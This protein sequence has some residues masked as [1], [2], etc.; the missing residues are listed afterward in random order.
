[1]VIGYIKAVM[2]RHT[3][4]VDD[5]PVTEPMDT[6]SELPEKEKMFSAK[7]IPK[8]EALFREA[9]ADGSGGLDMEEFCV[10][11]EQLYG[12]VN[13]EEIIAL[14]MQIDSDCNTT[15]DI[16]ELMDFLLNKNKALESMDYKNQ[17]FPKPIKITV[18]EHCKNIVRLLFCPSMFD[19]QPDHDP[20]VSIG[21]IRTYQAGQ[22]ISISSDGILNFWTN[23]IDNP[24]TIALYNLK[25][26]LPFSHVKKMSVNDMVYI[27][28]LKEL[29]ISTS[30]RELLFYNCAAF[31]E[32][33][34]I[35]YSLIVEDNI[36]NTMNYWYKDSRAVFSF[37]DIKGLL[38]VFVSY[39]IKKN[40]L[41]CKE[42]YE[43]I[44]L[45]DYPTVYV[46]SLLKNPSKDFLCFKVPVFNDM[47]SEIKYFPS[48]HSFAVCGSSSKTMVLVGLPKLPRTKVSKKAFESRVDKEFFTCVEYCP[49]AERLVTGGT[50]G[51]LRVW[52]PHKTMSCEQE[53]TGHVKP[54]THIEYNHV[55][56]VFVSLSKDKNVRVWSEDG[57]LCRQSF[58]AHEMKRAPISSVYYN[59]HNNEL[60]LANSDI[61]K[62]FGRGTD[63]FKDTLTSHDKPLCGAL[64]HSIFKQVV[65]V[66]QT[67]W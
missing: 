34:R 48:L 23:N 12:S 52:F 54:V 38:T 61:G 60:V 40:G 3:E 9:D 45:K 32:E 18:V 58:H 29:V 6:R 14:H 20:E 47:C 25:K 16:G 59:I 41:F 43:Q 57:W 67:M 37:G 42:A 35:G 7:D 19:G 21:Q 49:S 30:D 46:S 64:Y 17:T 27:T 63:V 26:R 51:L 11:M 56:K 31:P 10:V 8:I 66:C 4:M 5:L 39:D 53:L 33:F 36:V 15:V 28:E 62:Y 13:K 22:Y 44:S 2:D 50:D 65:S 24:H 55:D 1:M